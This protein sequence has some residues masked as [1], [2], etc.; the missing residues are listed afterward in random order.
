[1]QTRSAAVFSAA[2]HCEQAPQVTASWPYAPREVRS[3]D[4]LCRSTEQRVYAMT[5]QFAA[6]LGTCVR[7]AKRSAKRLVSAGF[8][9]AHNANG[10]GFTQDAHGMAEPGEH[11]MDAK[12]DAAAGSSVGA[13]ICMHVPRHQCM[14]HH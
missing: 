8:W 10:H 12:A 5:Q 3:K 4:L 6:Y 7:F 11:K 9:V 14:H 13:M 1:M 2:A